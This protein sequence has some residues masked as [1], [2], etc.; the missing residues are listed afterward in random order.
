MTAEATIKDFLAFLKIPK[1][2][3]AMVVRNGHVL[4]ADEQINH[5]AR[6]LLIPAVYGG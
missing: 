2:H 6:H 5:E 1:S 3:C 4:K